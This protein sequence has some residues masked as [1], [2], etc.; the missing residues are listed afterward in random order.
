METSGG[1]ELHSAIE[2]THATDGHTGGGR[3]EK[4]SSA[5]SST[6]GF[7][8]KRIQH[9]DIRGKYDSSGQPVIPDS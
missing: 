1:T 4:L 8:D 9:M 3:G 6:I 5:F 7:Q 2:A